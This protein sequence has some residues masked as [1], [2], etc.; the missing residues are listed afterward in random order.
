MGVCC[1]A[2]RR[3]GAPRPRRTTSHTTR[4]S[5]ALAPRASAA[6]LRLHRRLP[7][8]LL[9]PAGAAPPRPSAPHDRQ[10]CLQPTTRWRLG[11]RCLPVQGMG[12][13]APRDHHMQLVRAPPSQSPHRAPQPIGPRDPLV[14]AAKAPRPP[15]PARVPWRWR[16][17]LPPP[18]AKT[19]FRSQGLCLRLAR[20]WCSIGSASRPSAAALR[21]AAASRRVAA[22]PD[23]AAPHSPLLV[24]LPSLRRRP[25]QP[26]P[27]PWS[28]LPSSRARRQHHTATTTTTTTTS[29][30]CRGLRRRRGKGATF[31]EWALIPSQQLADQPVGAIMIRA[32]PLMRLPTR[33][34]HLPRNALVP[35]PTSVARRGVAPAPVPAPA[36]Q[37]CER[38]PWRLCTHCRVLGLCICWTLQSVM[39]QE[40]PS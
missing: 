11:R 17:Q 10:G 31:L 39:A 36:R 5:M 37:W 1:A 26:A 18:H 19:S 29:Q 25:P 22:W 20:P 15:R 30:R 23:A 27:S 38:L 35:L 8:L 9:D 34:L 7:P 32:L 24:A 13:S 4:P 2:R 21:G 12:H 28:R 6:P 16:R 40:K 14:A 3:V 33:R